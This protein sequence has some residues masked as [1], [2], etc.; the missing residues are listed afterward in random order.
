MPAAAVEAVAL[1]ECAGCGRSDLP[2]AA[3]TLCT[4]CF[5]LNDERVTAV[6]L[7][8]SGDVD[9]EDVRKYGIYDRYG[10]P[11]A[12]VLRIED[13]WSGAQQ[14]GMMSTGRIRL[15]TVP[16]VKALTV[17]ELKR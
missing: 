3:V 4:P 11:I 2:L 12:T 7:R 17:K 14:H 5:R 16:D 10:V 8:L 15:S 1:S 6:R 9:W 13:G